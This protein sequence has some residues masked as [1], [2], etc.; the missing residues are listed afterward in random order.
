[1]EKWL[2]EDEHERETSWFLL[3]TKKEAIMF[4]TNT[5]ITK[6]LA[7]FHMGMK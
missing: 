3:G 2:P 4:E 7:E 1:M 5:M 6:K